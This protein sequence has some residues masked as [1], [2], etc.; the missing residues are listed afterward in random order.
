[1]ASLAARAEVVKLGRTLDCDPDELAFLEAYPADELAELRRATGRALLEEHAPALRR[2]VAAARLLPAALVA[3]IS[4]QML[5]AP[6]AGRMATQMAPDRAARIV[7]HLSVD[8]LADVAAVLDPEG[9]REIV[10]Q[11]SD[12]RVV[13]VAEALLTRGDHLTLGRFVDQAGDG[14]VAHVLG[15]ADDEQLLHLA[16][17]LESTARLDAIM[18]GLDDARV[19]GAVRAAVEAGLP[20]EALTL[21]TAVEDDNLRRLATAVSRLDDAALTGIVRAS[22]DEGAW[23]DALRLVAAMAPDQ[24]R[25]MLALP[26]TREVEVLSAIVAASHEHDLWAGLVGLLELMEVG[27][28]RLLAEVELLYDPRVARGVLRASVEVR[29]WAPLLRVVDELDDAFSDRVAEA[30]AHVDAVELTAAIER[31]PADERERV[32]R[33]LPDDEDP[34]G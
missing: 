27:H 26:V 31:L 15:M 14:V 19:D 21:T 33:L 6:L 17:A 20:L 32:R 3:R 2:A 4:E 29:H 7:D 9:G 8:Y 28:L 1:M 22:T 13:E 11:L 34:T 5:D 10:V 18:D 25:R 23:P 30:L 16:L 24:Q 12:E